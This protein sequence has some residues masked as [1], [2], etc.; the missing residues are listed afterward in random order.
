MIWPTA[1]RVS[2]ALVAPLVA[3][4]LDSVGAVTSGRVPEPASRPRADWPL[5][6]VPKTSPQD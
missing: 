1:G 2:L 5:R 4:N 6:L 3:K